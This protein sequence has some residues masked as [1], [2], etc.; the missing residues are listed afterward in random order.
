M[1]VVGDPHGH[2]TRLS[3]LLRD[4]GLVDG[5]LRWIAGDARLLLIGDYFDH[6]P[7][8]VGVVELVMRLQEDAQGA[9]GQVDALLGNHD[10][11]ILSA[12]RFGGDHRASWLEAGGNRQELASLT[13]QHV[14]WLSALPALLLEE[15]H[16]C[17][18][19]DA[20]LYMQYGDSVQEVNEAVQDVLHCDDQSRW[21]GLLDEFGKHHAFEKEDGVVLARS[22]LQRF[23]GAQI[24]H[25]HTP[26]QKITGQPPDEV[27]EAQVYADGLCVNVDGGIY[28]GGSGFVYET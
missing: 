12:L 13:V 14:E 9:G 5:D 20:P 4:T 26:I 11:L 18:H 8:G 10:V 2:L 19:A 17:I 27:R 28:R 3:A 22:F 7:D 25:G 1:Y 15:D 21:T 23:G 24:L 16:L 6:G